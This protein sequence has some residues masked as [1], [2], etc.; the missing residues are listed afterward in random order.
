MSCTKLNNFG[1]FGADQHRP[2]QNL[3]HIEVIAH[4]NTV[5]LHI[6]LGSDLM[7]VVYSVYVMLVAIEGTDSN[8]VDTAFRVR[9]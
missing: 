2:I 9:E 8:L 6:D 5:K 3:L 7:S 4:V 1:V